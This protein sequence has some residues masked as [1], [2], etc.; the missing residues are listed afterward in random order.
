MRVLNINAVDC[1]LVLGLSL[2]LILPHPP[3]SPLVFTK[4]LSTFWQQDK[5]ANDMDKFTHTFLIRH[6][7]KILRSYLRL[8]KKEGKTTFFD[9]NEVAYK[10]LLEV[11]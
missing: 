9:V 8:Q 10:E 11:S 2:L 5:L 3:L 7:E 4:E 6:P 1:A